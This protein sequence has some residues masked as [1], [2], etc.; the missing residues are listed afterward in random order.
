[1]NLQLKHFISTGLSLI[2]A[3]LTLLG[4]AQAWEVCMWVG[5]AL[6]IIAIIISMTIRCP[7][8]GHN[9]VRRGWT[10]PKFCPECGQAIDGSEF[11]E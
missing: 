1:M 8:C 11:E 9:L 2:G 7:S 4:N 10:V 3:G 5:I 6:M